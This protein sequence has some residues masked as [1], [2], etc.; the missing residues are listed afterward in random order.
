MCLSFC[1]L[2]AIPQS[3]EGLH[4][5]SKEKF[6]LNSIEGIY[7]SKGGRIEDVQLVRYVIK[8]DHGK[9]SKILIYPSP[10]CLFLPCSA[11]VKHSPEER[12]Y[13]CICYKNE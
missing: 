9:Y 7:T 13:M 2:I 4:Q 6:N 5:L 11:S 8:N 12:A 3:I 10:E 1:K